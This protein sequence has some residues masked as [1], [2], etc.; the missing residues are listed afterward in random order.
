LAYI[1]EL[2]PMP[3]PRA[4]QYR[5]WVS[6]CTKCGQ[7]V[8]GQ[9]SDLAPDQY[10]VTAHRVG[11]RVMAAVHTLHYQFGIPEVDPISWTGGRLN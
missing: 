9:H 6:R 10:G 7:R 4:T 1:T 2:R 8:R 11:Q 5:V 3:R